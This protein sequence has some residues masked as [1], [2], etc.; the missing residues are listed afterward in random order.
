MPTQLIDYDGTG[1]GCP[2]CLDQADVPFAS[3]AA[4]VDH[5]VTHS[6]A[7]LAFVLLRYKAVV[8]YALVVVDEPGG[9]RTE[10]HL[11]EL[12]QEVDDTARRSPARPA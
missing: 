5:Y 7:E 3:D 8:Q 12:M 4:A 11:D 2:I 9:I 6:P 10:R 1:E